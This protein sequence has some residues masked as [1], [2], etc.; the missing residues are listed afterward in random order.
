LEDV[1]ALRMKYVDFLFGAD[2][3]TLL[4]YGVEY[5]YEIMIPANIIYISDYLANVFKSFTECDWSAYG[6]KS[7]IDRATFPRS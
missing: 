6:D 5:V 1:T 2:G 3:Q 4:Y 7:C